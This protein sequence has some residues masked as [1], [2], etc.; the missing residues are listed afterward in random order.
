MKKISP[1]RQAAYKILFKV[2]EGHA[3]ADLLL[4]SD[5]I[6]RLS[7]ADRHL[8]TALVLGVLRWQIRLDHAIKQ[9][10][11]KPNAKLDRAVL[12]G[13]RL[14]AFQLA[15][16]ERIPAHAA[17]N[18][19][20]ELV[21]Q[22]GH[23][24]AARMVNAVL[25]K[26]AA[27]SFSLANDI[28][29]DEKTLALD[30]AHPAW[31]VARWVEHYGAATSKKICAH[32]QTPPELHLRLATS[33]AEK[34][35]AETGIELAP[36]HW[37]QCAR[38]LRSGDL[39]TTTTLREG[40]AR[41]QDEGSQLIAELAAAAAPRAEKILDAC[42][43]PGGKTLV[44]AERHPQAKIVAQEANDRRCAELTERLA[45]L[46]ERVTIHC[47]DATQSPEDEIYDLILVDA[48]CSGT[49]TLGRNPE[50]R[51]RLRVEEFARQ[52]ERQ[53]AILA[54]SL[55]ALRPGGH[56]LYSTCSLEPEENQQVVDAVLASAPQI[57]QRSLHD[58]LATMEAD[59]IL[60]TGASVMLQGALTTTGA[61]QL[62]AGVHPADGFFAALLE[63]SF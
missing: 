25:R 23:R 4:R 35:L 36:A 14:G 62:I 32:G 30:T 18:E 47:G 19:S 39:F 48:P 44:L 1:A 10:I 60:L 55:K 17:I 53:R 58:A 37:L 15:A 22:S 28:A 41:V 52:A 40:R 7:A 31:M 5:N 29:E 43:A 61:L 33:E 42:A 34:E 27:A 11:A 46:G 50:I 38:V 57:R 2:D 24:F 6:A 56:L 51:H 12:I 26:C 3:H 63:K 54:S 13:L 45:A 16:M 59:G 20:V 49:G 8:T 21:N 9:F